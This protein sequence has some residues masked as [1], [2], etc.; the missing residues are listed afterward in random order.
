MFQTTSF[1]GIAG[2]L[3]QQE[4]LLEAARERW[5][6]QARSQEKPRKP[7]RAFKLVAR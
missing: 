1:H 2:Q 3:K 6:A 7:N 5:A 4:M